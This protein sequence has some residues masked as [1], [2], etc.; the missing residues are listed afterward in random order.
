VG[1]PCWEGISARGLD[2]LRAIR[3]DVDG[4]LNT[5]RDAR[6]RSTRLPDAY[7]W[8]DAY[9]L[10]AMCALATRHRLGEGQHWAVELSNLAARS[11]MREL[12]VRALVHRAA[13]GDGENLDV[14]AS[15]AAG[16]DN[17]VI[18]RLIAAS[19]VPT[20]A[21]S[22]TTTGCGSRP[23]PPTT[24]PGY[25]GGTGGTLAQLEARRRAHAR[26][27]DRIRCAKDTGLNHPP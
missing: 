17:P 16:I 2:L 8:V 13:L 20:T 7:L 23:S 10:D 3:G 12:V 1:D 19:S 22:P 15:L 6:L 5:L 25:H 26:V 27:E 9:T 14:A 21:G 24:P 4:A 18:A 11:G